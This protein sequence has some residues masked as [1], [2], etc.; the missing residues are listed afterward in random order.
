M[1]NSSSHSFLSHSFPSSHKEILDM[2]IQFLHGN[3]TERDSKLLMDHIQRMASGEAPFF[4]TTLS[5]VYDKLV[6][7]AFSKHTSPGSGLGSQNVA[8]PTPPLQTSISNP[9]V[10]SNSQAP[11]H[12]PKPIS[13]N[14]TIKQ[15][16][17]KCARCSSVASIHNLRDGLHCP[18]CP[19]T[20][21]NG[22]GEKGWPFMRCKGCDHLR[23]MRVGSCVKANCSGVFT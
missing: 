9:S 4:A 11:T 12:A 23:E 21:R 6:E 22:R 15:V 16:G 8:T 14:T 7:N 3:L 17:L 18:L 2:E 5:L 13:S 10:A 19:A 20:G 1:S